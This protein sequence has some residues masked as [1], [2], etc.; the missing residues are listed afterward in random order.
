[1]SRRVTSSSVH[2]DG[3]NHDG[4]EA[5]DGANGRRPRIVRGKS[6][7]GDEPRSRR[8]APRSASS[9][10]AGA[11]SRAVSP[12]PADSSLTKR[13]GGSGDVDSSRGSGF[14]DARR[15]HARIPVSRQLDDAFERSNES[16]K[17]IDANAR[18]KERRRVGFRVTAARVA[19]VVGVVSLLSLLT[20]ALCFSPLLILHADEVTVTGANEWVSASSVAQVASEKAGTSLVLVSSKQISSQI[21][22]M[23]GVTSVT[24]TKQFPHG[25]AIDVKAQ[26]P[27]ALLKDGDGRLTAVDDKGAV[28]NSARSNTEGIPVIEVADIDKGLKN[29]AVVQAIK[30]LAQMPESMRA[31]VQEVSAKTQDSVTTKLNDGHTVVWGDA[32][33]MELKVAIVTKVLADPNVIGSYGQVDVSA[34]SRPILK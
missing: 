31:N 19:S 18:I 23:A 5:D 3:S 24:V 10:L 22:A 12:R 15:L 13:G 28:L 32:T 29:R 7:E 11:A 26:R 9:S 21:Q 17:I 25:I 2:D 34:P 33:Q 30:V 16:S 14:V 4:R 1:M 8:G 20:W 6:G 27:A